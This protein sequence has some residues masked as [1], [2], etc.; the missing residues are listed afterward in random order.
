MLKTD[1]KFST[2]ICYRRKERKGNLEMPVGSYI[3]R[4]IYEYLSKEGISVCYEVKNFQLADIYKERTFE[5]LEQVR[6][7]N[8][9]N[10]D[11]YLELMHA[12]TRYLKKHEDSSIHPQ[13]RF[14]FIPIIL[15]S[16]HDDIKRELIYSKL[17]ALKT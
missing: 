15:D 2:F 16:F 3:A 12:V 6:Y 17:T 9:Q 10:D 7:V 11:V 13:S 8:R 5:I 14:R 1:N 4:K